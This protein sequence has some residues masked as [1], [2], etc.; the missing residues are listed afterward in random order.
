[1]CLVCGKHNIVEVLISVSCRA[2]EDLKY[3]LSFPWS[4]LW[5]FQGS[6]RN[7]R[8]LVGLARPLLEVLF[9]MTTTLLRQSALA[10]VH[11][12]AHVLTWTQRDHSLL[13]LC[14]QV[15]MELAP[16]S[17][18]IFCTGYDPDFFLYVLAANWATSHAG[19]SR[20]KWK[21]TWKKVWRGSCQTALLLLSAFAE[22]AF[23]LSHCFFLMS[24]CRI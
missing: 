19:L 11:A 3:I 17:E 12:N 23:S 13:L 10:I 20:Y 4:S 16:H 2:R 18:G 7:T 5:A 6:W 14:F 9:L 24:L 1:M 21:C 8:V 22:W 15:G